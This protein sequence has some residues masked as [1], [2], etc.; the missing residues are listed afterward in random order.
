MRPRK[1]RTVSVSDERERVAAEPGH[2][3]GDLRHGVVVVEERAVAGACRGPR[4]R[5]QAMPFSAVSIR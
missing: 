3:L 1:A 4:S 5:I 2:G